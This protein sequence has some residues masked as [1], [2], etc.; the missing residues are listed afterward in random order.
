MMEEGKGRVEEEEE[1]FEGVE[2]WRRI[3]LEGVKLIRGRSK[4]EK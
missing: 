2:Q 1:S 4:V 3:H